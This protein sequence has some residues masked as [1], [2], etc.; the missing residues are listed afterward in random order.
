[1]DD[2]DYERVMKLKWCIHKNK[3]TGKVYAVSAIRKE[4]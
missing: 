2:E 3:K 4:N 1:V